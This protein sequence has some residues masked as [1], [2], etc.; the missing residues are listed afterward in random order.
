MA[1]IEIFW[2]IGHKITGHNIEG[3]RAIGFRKFTAFFGTSPMI[4]AIVWHL[5]R[6]TRPDGSTPE[7]LLWA[8]L[9][10]KRYTIENVNAILVKTSEKTFRK[11]SHIFINLLASIPLVRAIYYYS[12]T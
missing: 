5:L 12:Q 6:E 9:L 3:S 10:L 8:L 2:N 4:C 7:H 11:W 1:S